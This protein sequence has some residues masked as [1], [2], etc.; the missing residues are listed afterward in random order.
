MRRVLVAALILTV[1]AWVAWRVASHPRAP[2][3]PPAAGADSASAG[4]QLVQVY[5][6]SPGAD[7]LVSETREVAEAATLHDRVAGLVRELDRGP[8]RG[9]VAVL[10]AGT[11]AVFAYQDPNGLL[12]VDLSR[13]LVQG[14]QGGSSTEYLAV[15]SLVRTLA[16]NMSG[17]K[18]ILLV[19]GGEP[20]A[21]LGGHLPLDRPMD[22]SDWP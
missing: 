7:S 13:S 14:F 18:R 11:S 4:L 21:T 17:V 9:G 19:C 10:P 6:A 20:M 12:T 5:F 15:A 2:H 8:T 16:A 22:V 3:A 1:L